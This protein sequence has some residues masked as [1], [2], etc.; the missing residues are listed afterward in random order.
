MMVLVMLIGTLS[1]PNEGLAQNCNTAVKRFVNNTAFT[2]QIQVQVTDCAGSG[3]TPVIDLPPGVWTQS[4]LVGWPA[5]YNGCCIGEVFDVAA[6]Q[7]YG[8]GGNS[9]LHSTP[10]SDLLISGRRLRFR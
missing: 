9:N 6:G 4:T 10:W 8:W 7:W 1:L 2:I 3:I 5:A